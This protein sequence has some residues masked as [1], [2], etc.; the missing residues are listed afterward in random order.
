MVVPKVASNMKKQQPT[1]NGV[2]EI[3][4]KAQS[5]EELGLTVEAV[6]EYKKLF[7][8][9][10]HPAK[11]VPGLVA[12]LVKTNA[13]SKIMSRVQEMVSQYKLNDGRLAQL[14]FSLGVE[15][16]R[17]GHPDL[18]LDVYKA[19]AEMDPENKNI[20]LKIDQIVSKLSP[21]S[22]YDYLLNKGLATPEQLQ[23]ALSASKSSKK[24]V[25]FIP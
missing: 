9:E 7:A 20:K 25:E 11:I 14:R 12:C 19:T 17:M 2:E 3:L 21:A 24:S 1:P 15:M 10:C 6:A 4:S 22:K 8:T 16:E 13:P 18:A 5:L 23:K